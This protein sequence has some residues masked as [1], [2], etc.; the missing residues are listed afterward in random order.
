MPTSF[1][2]FCGVAYLRIICVCTDAFVPG[3]GPAAHVDLYNATGKLW[4]RFPQGLGQARSDLAAASLSSGLVF[5]AGGFTGSTI[6]LLWRLRRAR[7]CCC[8]VTTTC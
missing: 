2:N 1:C 6:L 5:F 4:I 3:T 8:G 7:L